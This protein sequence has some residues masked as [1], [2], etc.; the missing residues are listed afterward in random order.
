MVS[1]GAASQPILSLQR[2]LYNTIMR[3]AIAEW[4]VS[5]VAG[6]QSFDS[7]MIR[8]RSIVLAVLI[9]GPPLVTILTYVL[10]IDP[11]FWAIKIPETLVPGTVQGLIGWIIS[12]LIYDFTRLILFIK[13]KTILLPS[14]KTGS[15]EGV[16]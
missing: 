15:T 8:G 13:L 5:H 11:F 2:I 3:A 6:V 10:D 12:A 14:G 4:L 1:Y 7:F 9:Y 16:R